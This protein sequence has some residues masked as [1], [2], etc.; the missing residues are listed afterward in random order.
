MLRNEVCDEVCN[1]FRCKYDNFACRCSPYCMP[2]DYGKCKP[3]CLVKDC[4]YD[5]VSSD[6]SK[7]CYDE[8]LIKYTIYQQSFT[9]NTNAIVSFE[10]CSVASSNK[11]NLTMSLDYKSYYP[12]CFFEECNFGLCHLNDGYHG[13]PNIPQSFP[14]KCSIYDCYL[15]NL[16]Y[17]YPST[18]SIGEFALTD[19]NYWKFFK[20]P[21]FQFYYVTSIQKGS[22]PSGNG[23]AISPFETLDYALQFKLPINQSLADPSILENQILYFYLF[24][25]GNYTLTDCDPL[26]KPSSVVIGS[27]DGSKILIKINGWSRLSCSMISYIKFENVIID[28]SGQDNGCDSI[29]CDYCAYSFYN[30]SDGYYYNDRN[31]RISQNISLDSCQIDKT[32]SLSLFHADSELTLRNV[33]IRNFRF[34]YDSIISGNG[35][36]ELINVIFDN[37]WLSGKETNAVVHP[38]GNFTYLGG[39]V[40]RLNNGFEFGDPLDFRGFL[41]SESY[42]TF[43]IKNVDFKYNLVY[44]KPKSSLSTGSL[45]YISNLKKFEID[46]CTFMHNYCE[47]GIFYSKLNIER[48]DSSINETFYLTY[49][50]I[51]HIIIKNTNF[52]S[53][54]GKFGLIRVEFLAL[55]LNVH[56]SNLT[57]DSNGA[58]SDSLIYIY[59]SAVLDY[60]KTKTTQTIVFNNFRYVDAISVPRWCKFID[61]SFKNNHAKGMI[62]T[63]NLVNFDL[64]NLTI[65]SNGSPYEDSNVNSLILKYFIE[66]RD[67]YDLYLSKPKYNAKAVDCE[68][69]VSLS[70]SINLY[71]EDVNITKNI[72]RNSSPTFIIDDSDSNSLNSLS[73]SGNVGNG[74]SP[75]CFYF[76]GSYDRNFTNL[77]FIENINNY[78][79][80]Y[81]ALGVESE[82]TLYISNCSFINNLAGLSP[83]VYFSGV[84]I[85]IESSI[86][87]SNESRQ[88]NGGALYFVSLF[89]N[90]KISWLII[91]L[92]DFIRNSA[93]SNGGAIFLI[94]SSRS[95]ESLDFKILESNFIGNYANNG[96]AL[97]IDSSVALSKESVILVSNFNENVSKQSGT[98]ILYFS[99]GIL[100]FKSCVFIENSSYLAAVLGIDIGED[101]KNLPS[102]ICIELSIFRKNTGNSVIYTDSQN[103]NSTVETKNSVFEYNN[104]RVVF[105]NFD[106]FTDNGSVF[107]FN[108]AP[109]GSC[110]YL[111]NSAILYASSSQFLNN[112]CEEYGGAISITSKSF[113]YC[114]SCS[115]IQNKAKRKGGVLNAEQESQFFIL[116][117]KFEKNSCENDGSAI[118]AFNCN[119]V[120]SSLILS[121]F[122]NNYA[123]N[124]GLINMVSSKIVISSS[125]FSNNSAEGYT[126]GLSLTYSNAEIYDSKFENQ[127]SISGSFIYLLAESNAYVANATFSNGK[128]SE[129]GGAIYA[130]SSVLLIKDS[131]FNKLSSPSGGAIYAS[132]DSQISINSSNFVDIESLIG[133]GVIN[134][135]QV[136]L[137]IENSIFNKF[138]VTGIYGK[139]IKKLEIVNSSFS[140]GSGND[141]GALYCDSCRNI[142]IIYCNFANNF[143]SLHGG[144]LFF[145][146]TKDISSNANVTSSKFLNNS[147]QNGGAIYSNNANLKIIFSNFKQNKAIS[148]QDLTNKNIDSGIGGGINMNCFDTKKC[149]FDINSSVFIENFAEYNGG[150]ISWDDQTPSLFNNTYKNNAA[151]Y[152]KDI[153]SY[154]IKLMQVKADGSLAGF[155]SKRLLSDPVSSLNLTEIAPGQRIKN[156][157]QIALV[158]DLNHIIATDN[159]S[160]AVLKSTS[161]R[162]QISGTT[163]VTASKG[164]FNFSELV[165][166]AEPGSN[167]QII[168]T[169]SAIDISKIKSSGQSNYS[170]NLILN[171]NMRKCKIGEVISG[172]NCQICPHGF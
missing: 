2:E 44:L 12:E 72:C 141:G 31:Q 121:Q 52:I 48:Y 30:E 114:E 134:V 152:G 77:K 54:Y 90:N 17:C 79:S 80:G 81:G 170:Q 6:S 149:K 111:Q 15:C 91:S 169:S 74:P 14:N 165:I 106:Y 138:S 112:T 137:S 167:I 61:I 24:N 119:L 3:A 123:S 18:F 140:N 49:M 115:F 76:T 150:G 144:A 51:T 100:S 92:S 171:V 145:K 83:A 116:N 101:T 43:I 148:S 156:Q 96:A 128:S 40:T 172:K 107:Q 158:D 95:S 38:H 93:S 85:F 73:C 37:I 104:A 13:C 32:G 89:Q 136:E 65:D 66:N 75:V 47:T 70:K 166:S 97:Y 131:F 110:F 160:E 63:V 163:K 84:S 162:T 64:K 126:P 87:D 78:I 103:R 67:A 55:L 142:E 129:R 28:G 29:Y 118:Y 164:I 98:I 135:N 153:A 9:Y 143:A 130:S 109:Y 25:D 57:I 1:T 122:T 71:I 16:T 154:P 58:E 7:W 23:T 161:L 146:S 86:F 45:I 155:N 69:M 22:Y 82:N 33:E 19:I 68:F 117:S 151:Q 159:V 147:A 21:D 94:Q 62:T 11:C 46:N 39:S 88:G 53:N 50:T 60:Y 26:E 42:S 168:A 34:N 41:Y 59:N 139:Q 56:L 35:T 5:R 4:K 36:I 105:L 125:I 124:L 10:I 133:G 102:K 108:S 113:F 27:Y 8:E 127:R 99:S 157:L 20:H 132:F 120:A